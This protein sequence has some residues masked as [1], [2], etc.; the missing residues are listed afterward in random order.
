MSY[1]L[2]ALKKSDQQ[3]QLSATPTLLTTQ[4]PM[5]APTQ[6]AYL[7]FGIFATVLL[8]AGI[9]IGWLRPWHAEPTR[10][11][12]LIAAQSALSTSHQNTLAPLPKPP[13]MAGRTRQE[14]PAS[15]HPSM[16]AAKKQPLPA[17]TRV[18]MHS[19]PAK[20]A[21]VIPTPLQDKYDD[22]A[23]EQKA[24]PMAELPLALQ[25]E[26]PS[27]TVQVHAYSNKP[28]GRLASINN[29]MLREGDMLSPGLRLEQITPDGLIFSY[30][31]YRFRRG[32]Q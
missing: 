24:V 30:K 14:L 5:I 12:D 11:K 10:A 13:E 26:I 1:I 27:M 19:A 7:Y 16:I 23:Q 22:A 15:Q 31:E 6:P 2:E 25:Q 21:S 4:S 17:P 9:L 29:R 8:G 18:A 28:K 20:A 32:V 3:R